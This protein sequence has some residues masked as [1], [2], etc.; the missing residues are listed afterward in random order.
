MSLCE[1]IKEKFF[2]C[3]KYIMPNPAVEKLDTKN[4][5]EIQEINEKLK[6]HPDLLSIFKLLVIIAN[7]RLNDDRIINAVEDI[8]EDDEIWGIN[9]MPELCDHSSDEDDKE[10]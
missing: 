8:M 3:L 6:G 4:I 5:F 9:E 1:V 10:D 7:K 2:V